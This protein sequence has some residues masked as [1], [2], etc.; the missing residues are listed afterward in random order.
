MATETTARAEQP[1]PDAPDEGG[2]EAFCTALSASVRG[3]AFLAEYTRRNRNADTEQLLAAIG[4]LQTSMAAN[5]AP[6][7]AD[8]VKAQLRAL[9][10]DIDEEQCELEASIVAIKAGK[11]AELVAM[12]ERRIADIVASMHT[13]SAPQAKVEGSGLPDETVEAAERAH[14]AV[15]PIPE[16][17]ELPIPSPVA[18]QPPP[19]TLVHSET[20][21]AEVVFIEPQPA[22]QPAPPAPD[23]KPAS[24][25]IEMPT[26]EAA[27]PAPAQ[28]KPIAMPVATPA[29]KPAKPT[30]PANP[31]AS[32]M[33]LSEEER[34]ALFT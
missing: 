8:S 13:G 25:M 18:T 10:N 6:V 1:P 23:V 4:K 34:L 30:M 24:V 20:I 15:V 3:R 5:A 31:L 17:P 11:L 2:Y 27:I 32:I 29:A 22:P 19:I 12:V 16:Q 14:L 9:L 33:A 28:T 26:I 21:M 7:V